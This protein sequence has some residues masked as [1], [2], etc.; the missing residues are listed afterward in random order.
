MMKGFFAKL[1]G[2]QCFL[3]NPLSTSIMTDAT[4]SA[5]AVET[6][7]EST[8][9]AVT[10]AAPK[11]SKMALA[12]P[13]LEQLKQLYPAVFG[14]KAMPLKRGIFQ[15]LL[16]ANP[17][18]FEKDS[19]KAALG[20]YTR[21]TR[22]LNAMAHG[23]SRVNLQAEPVEALAPEH[24]Y[25]SLL[26]V[27]R[28]RHAKTG[29]DV[30]APLRKRMMTAFEDSGLSASDY[31]ARM[32]CKDEAANQLLAQAVERASVQ[33]AKDEA[34]L[35]AFEASGQSTTEFVR[36][37]GLQGLQTLQML[38]R[39]Q[40]RQQAALASAHVPA[41]DEDEAP[42]ATDAEQDNSQASA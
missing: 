6:A 15:D 5:D 31:I 41:N 16:A 35:R 1:F 18:V 29:E 38:D 4:P 28:R 33:I 32:T 7:A 40:R 11:P 23:G 10:A 37:Y 25:Q 42:S 26:E 19:L 20:V 17:D 12:K 9:V 2:W 22:Y 36:T 13:V 3:T 21:S 8:A 30:R 34:V 24:V 39:A 27:F 14:E